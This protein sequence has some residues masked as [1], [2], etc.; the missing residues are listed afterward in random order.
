MGKSRWQMVAFM[1]EGTG[2]ESGKICG[3][4]R[5][6]S[7]IQEKRNNGILPPL[8]ESQSANL[9]SR[10]VPSHV[11]F[12]HIATSFEFHIFSIRILKI[13]THTHTHICL[14]QIS[15]DSSSSSNHPHP[16]WHHNLSVALF[17]CTLTCSINLSVSDSLIPFPEN[18]SNSLPPPAFALFSDLSPNPQSVRLALFLLLT[19]PLLLLS[20]ASSSLLPHTYATRPQSHS[21][22]SLPSMPF[23]PSIH[24]SFIDPSPNPLIHDISVFS[25]NPYF[26]TIISLDL[27][28]EISHVHLSLDIPWNSILSH[29]QTTLYP[30]DIKAFSN[31]SAAFPYAFPD[32]SMRAT[33]IFCIDRF[34][35]VSFLIQGW[36]VHTSCLLCYDRW[37]SAS[38]S[39][40]FGTRLPSTQIH[41]CCCCRLCL[42][43]SW[44][45][46]L[47]CQSRFGYSLRRPRALSIPSTLSSAS[48]IAP[49]P[50]HWHL[51]SKCRASP[52]NLK[53][54]P[55][56]D[57]IVLIWKESP[58]SA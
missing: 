53:K 43:A 42:F 21:I 46:Y 39:G 54:H 51:A 52:I 25:G 40:N 16:R 2:N 22:P 45:K 12:A 17:S 28:W 47:V 57:E 34:V 13:H 5:A 31:M 9:G 19:N 29:P 8:E 14:L 15:T 37:S 50:Q 36:I 49:L 11:F 10:W 58:D 55:G 24:P 23:L 18:S 3:E 7:E 38:S 41:S 35:S 6:F 33:G 56:L 48:L 30:F 32:M 4:M 26:H 1:K 44:G 27:I 20:L